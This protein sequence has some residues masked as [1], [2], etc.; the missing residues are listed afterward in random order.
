MSVR[1]IIIGLLASLV[2]LQLYANKISSDQQLS[3]FKQ[4]EMLHQRNKKL[5]QR[6]LTTLNTR[7]DLSSVQHFFTKNAEI[8][9]VH[10]GGKKKR[11]VV[12]KDRFLLALTHQCSQ[13]RIHIEKLISSDSDV[14]AQYMLHS[15]EGVQLRQYMVEFTLHH[16]KITHMVSMSK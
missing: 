8:E 1:L 10:G 9:V 5:V 16:N 6:F 13:C 12:V 3:K 7:F 2:S 11:D 15:P 4:Q 14:V